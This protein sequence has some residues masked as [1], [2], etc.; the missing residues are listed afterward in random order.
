AA[1]PDA[2]APRVPA[3]WAPWFELTHDTFAAWRE[4]SARERMSEALRSSIVESALA[5]VITTDRRGRVVEFNPSAQAMLGRSREEALGRSV[6]DIIIPDRYRAAHDAALDR[7]AAGGAPHLLGRRVEMVARRADGSE[8]PVEMVLWRTTVGDDTFYTASM[9]DLTESRRA[10]QE[11]ERQREALRQSEKL[12]A[13]GSLLA[14]VAHELNNPLAIVMGRASL[15]EAKCDDAALREDVL[16][17]RD[18]AERCGRIVRAFL[19]MARKKAVERTPVQLDATV[20]TAVDLLAYS[21][22]T[23]GIEVELRLA[24][25]L[26]PVRA[27]AGQLGQVVLNLLV[28]AQQALAAREPPRRVLVET[29]LDPA[30][31]DRG[32][33]VWL[34]VADN[35]PGIEPAAA[36]RVFE[37]FFTTKAEGAGTGLGLAVSHTVAREHGGSLVLEPTSPLGSGASFRL[38]LPVEAAPDGPA[39]TAPHDV[40]EAACARVLVVD[41]EPELAD[42]MREMLESAGFDVATAESGEVALELLDAARF[43]AIVSDL[44]MPGMDGPALARAVGERR[45]ALAARMVFVTGDTLSSTARDFLERGARPCIDKPFARADLVGAVRAVLSS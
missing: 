33:S 40:A 43:D 24:E 16:R 45:P 37:P 44:R 23:G 11:I 4:A 38:D 15:L 22:R 30:R 42:V 41:D 29:G 5:A 21:L 12:T 18:A 8:L 32:A 10:E 13:M 17:I 14:G 9:F 27:D 20:R 28:N 6:G 3:S 1:D 26:P 19:A 7:L 39:A 31:P 2:P 36:A 34:R 35:G 25:S